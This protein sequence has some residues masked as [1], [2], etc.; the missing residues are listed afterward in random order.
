MFS[1]IKLC[2]QICTDTQA[3]RDRD[4]EG[5]KAVDKLFRFFH[6]VCTWCESSS[7]GMLVL[8]NQKKFVFHAVSLSVG[9]YKQIII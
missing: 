4:R 5:Q 7:A 2:T 3:R 9:V 8:I 6:K 1:Y